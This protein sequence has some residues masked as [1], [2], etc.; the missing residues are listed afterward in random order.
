MFESYCSQSQS[1]IFNPTAARSQPRRVIMTVT[2][3]SS[4]RDN[5]FP[6]E[7]SHDSQKLISQYFKESKNIEKQPDHSARGTKRNLKDLQRKYDNI[8]SQPIQVPPVIELPRFRDGN[9][10]FFC[11]INQKTP[12]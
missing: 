4:R 2:E 1:V 10:F 12:R 8:Y 9:F 11:E 6:A 3:D 5:H 7:N